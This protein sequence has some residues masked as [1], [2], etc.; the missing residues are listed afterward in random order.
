[1]DL[2]LYRFYESV[3]QVTLLEVLKRT[4]TRKVTT[5]EAKIL[6]LRS[7]VKEVVLTTK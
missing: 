7:G 4:A 2:N 3:T 6:N 5:N 1:M